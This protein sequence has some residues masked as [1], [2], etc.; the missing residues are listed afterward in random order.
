MT[1]M[2]TVCGVMTIGQQLDVSSACEGTSNDLL[3]M[4]TCYVEQ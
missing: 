3:Q 1:S 2:M 4:I